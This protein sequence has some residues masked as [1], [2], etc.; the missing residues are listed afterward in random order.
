VRVRFPSHFDQSLL[1]LQRHVITYS[2]SRSRLAVTRRDSGMITYKDPKHRWA[3]TNTLTSTFFVYEMTNSACKSYEELYRICW[4][5]VTCVCTRRT[6]LVRNRR[7]FIRECPFW[8]LN[9]LKVLLWWRVNYKIIFVAEMSIFLTLRF[10]EGM[11]LSVQWCVMFRSVQSTC[12][13]Y[14][15]SPPLAV[16]VAST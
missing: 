3:K 9:K 13:H 2:L 16:R 4:W 8:L 14:S 6:I 12:Y 11:R 10:I 1:I 15:G 7:I 5:L